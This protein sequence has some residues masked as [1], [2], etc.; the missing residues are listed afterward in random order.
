METHIVSSRIGN[1]ERHVKVYEDGTLSP[2]SFVLR[3]PEEAVAFAD[4]LRV[5]AQRARE[6]L[7]P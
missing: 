4:L 6:I 5:A 2:E 7:N 3:S 1:T